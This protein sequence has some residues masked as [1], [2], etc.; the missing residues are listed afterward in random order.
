MYIN[1]HCLSVQ[2]HRELQAMADS[3][4]HFDLNNASGTWQALESKIQWLATLEARK[5]SPN[6]KTF[7]KA[8]S[9]LL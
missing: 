3:E 4:V 1:I 5:S 6:C 9:I 7:Q 2:L 8:S